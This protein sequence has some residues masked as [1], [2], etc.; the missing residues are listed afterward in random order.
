VTTQIKQMD[1]GEEE[2]TQISNTK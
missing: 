2:C 1:G